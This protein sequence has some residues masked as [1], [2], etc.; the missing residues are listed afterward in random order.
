MPIYVS[1][2]GLTNLKTE[3]SR[4]WREYDE[5]CA[6]RTV[7]HALSGD[8]WHDNPH[9]N[10]LQQLEA[11]KNREIAELQRL[12]GTSVVID[13]SSRARDRVAIGAIVQLR[14][15]DLDSGDEIEQ[16]W[17]ISGYNENEPYLRRL[18]YNS[19]LAAPIIGLMPGE[20]V[21]TR[22]PRGL[23]LIEILA[24]LEKWP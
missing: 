9:F 13:P 8:G 19:P 15:T 5:I 12:I 3:L 14:I 21:E 2:S 22:L 17:E 1:D 6:E 4:K 20:E 23:A 10:R 11:N 7:A 16:A 18:A 24:L